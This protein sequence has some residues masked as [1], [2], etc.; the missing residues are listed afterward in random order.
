MATRLV[1]DGYGQLEIN[2]CAFRRDGRIEAQCKPDATDFSDAVVENGM[3]LAVDNVARTVKFAV[4]SSLPVAL[5]YSAE[6]MYDERK[7]GLKNFYLNGENDFLPR[8][9]F[10]S[11]GDKYTTNCV[12]YNS[13]EFADESA[14][15]S[16]LD[17]LDSTPLWAGI[18]ASGAHLVSATAPTIGPK[19]RVIKKTT[20]PDGTLGLKMQVYVD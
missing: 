4:D 6:H 7:P 14:L 19:I 17:A 9:G 11:V 1:I 15:E 8:L 12:A 10:L 20:M 5:V 13:S 3:I 16:A 18:D 2:N